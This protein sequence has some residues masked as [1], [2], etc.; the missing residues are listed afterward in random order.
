MNNKKKIIILVLWNI[1]L[2]SRYKFLNYL[3]TQYKKKNIL[4]VFAIFVYLVLCLN[5]LNSKT[6]GS[7]FMR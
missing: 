3:D 7:I 1:I 6:N 2:F 5:A 4:A